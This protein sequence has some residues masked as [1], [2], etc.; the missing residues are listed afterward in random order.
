MSD[1]SAAIEFFRR[2]KR[3]GARV[4]R[5]FVVEPLGRRANVVETFPLSTQG[6]RAPNSDAIFTVLIPTLDRAVTLA[7]TIRTCLSQDDQNLRVIVSDNASSDN[8]A[9]VVALF[10]DARLSYVNPGRRLGM[11]EHW[12]F[13]I[14]H[15]GDGYLTVLGDDD[16][17]LPNAVLSA[18]L[19]IARYNTKALTWQK[20]EYHWPDHIIAE[21]RDWLQVP[22]STDVVKTKTRDAV[23]DVIGFRASYSRLPCIYNSFIS[24]DLIR[25]YR[26]KNDSVFFSGLA[27]DVYSAFAIAS[28]IEEFIFCQRPLSINGAS[29]K[30]N[31]TIQ[32]V[33]DREDQLAKSFWKD[34]KFTFEPGIP[35]SHVV[36][37]FIVD[38]FLKVRRTTGCFSSDIVDNE[39]LIRSVVGSTFG[40]YI[41][42]G[43]REERLGALKTYADSV[44][45]RTLFDDVCDRGSRAAATAGLPKP[46]YHH[47][48][49]IVFD[50]SMLG[51][52]DVHAATLRA[53]EVLDLMV[54]EDDLFKRLLK[55]RRPD[56]AVALFARAKAGVL[57]LHLGCGGVYLDGYVNVDFPQSEHNVM[58]VKPDVFC[59]LTEIDLPEQ[60]VE[61]VRL[62]HVFEHLNRAVAL[63]SVIKWHRWLR[64]GGKLHV[65]TPDFEASVRDFLN[66]DDIRT[67]MRAIR[68][69][70]GD[71]ADGWAYHVGQWFPERFERTFKQFGFDQTEIR[72]EDSGHTP[73]LRN[74]VAIGTKTVSRSAREQYEAGCE[75]LRDTMVADE[76][77]P[78]WEV[79]KKQLAGV[80]GAEAVPVPTRFH[81][82]SHDEPLKS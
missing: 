75:L 5:R 77:A 8:T 61:E 2:V 81:P 69:L 36:E 60:S 16:G 54:G 3:V 42:V 28:Q 71:Q 18:R 74:V 21:F 80:L 11:S 65:E 50:A 79:W 10:S 57:R 39:M 1:G 78:T 32:T 29:S 15:V 31:G 34:T 7:H 22:L 45:L 70:E 38:A 44:G 73:P 25:A 56:L 13:A 27:P 24:T 6:G 49:S 26:T 66:A 47:P 14:S 9:E 19:L 51:V 62:H 67:K 82:Q 52:R 4:F 72:R 33:G 48:H 23:K 46:G 43:R 40:G 41:P 17:L 68:H 63:A 37:F 20:I 55:T 35:E 30:S 58:T 64:V 12:E 76:E 59:D 53:A